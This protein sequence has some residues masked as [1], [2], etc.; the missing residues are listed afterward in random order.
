MSTV[1]LSPKYQVVIPQRVRE[2]MR[3]KPGERFHVINYDG[4]VELVPVRKMSEMRGFLRG[5]TS[6]IPRDDEDRL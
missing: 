3:L 1:T 4:R 5:L 2:K 6:D